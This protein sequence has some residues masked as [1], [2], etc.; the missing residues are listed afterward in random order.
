MF[1]IN[2]IQYIDHVWS[3]IPKI[4]KPDILDMGCGTGEPAIALVNLS[5][6]IIYA[7]D[8]DQ[9][10]LDWFSEKVTLMSL[11][12]RINIYR[13]SVFNMDFQG[14][15]FDIIWA[16][17]LFNII[18]FKNGLLLSSEHIKSP[19]IL[20]IHDDLQHRDKKEKMISENGYNLINTFKLPDNAWWEE[21]YSPMENF[22]KSIGT[23]EI[24]N[25][26]KNELIEI[27]SCKKNTEMFKSIYYILQ[28]QQK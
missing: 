9:E 20:V 23:D 10:A 6:G 14:L 18:G 24:E 12:D 5:D 25:K 27:E 4:E 28:K 26:F 16:E 19:G 22:L 3:F 15:K 13:N 2:I 7:V 1:R 8:N 21:Y 17:G 11:G